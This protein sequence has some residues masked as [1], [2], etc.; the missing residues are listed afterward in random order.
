MVRYPW[1]GNVR[2]LEN[3]VE[4]AV[5]LSTGTVL[6]LALSELR[7][8]AEAAATSLTL[9]D[10]EREHILRLLRETNW[11]LAGPGGAAER[12]GMKRT[13]VQSRMK[14]LGIRRPV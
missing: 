6:R 2:E 3:F 11:R 5:I 12:L 8:G 1:P 9:G 10:A 7:T 14:K 13:T 4:R